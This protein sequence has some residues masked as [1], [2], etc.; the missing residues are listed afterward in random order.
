MGSVAQLGE[1]LRC[2][3]EGCGFDSL[4][5][6]PS[7]RTRGLG[8]T[9]SLTEMSTR[10]LHWRKWN[11]GGGV[12][13][14]QPCH[15]HVPTVQKFWQPQ[16][17]ECLWACTGVARW[18]RLL[19]PRPRPPY[20]QV[21]SNNC[22]VPAYNKPWSVDSPVHSQKKPPHSSSLHYEVCKQD[23]HKINNL[24]SK[25]NLTVKNMKGSLD[26]RNVTRHMKYMTLVT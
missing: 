7:C 22:Q 12:Q 23:V 2:K 18:G 17:S 3:S 25:R 14:W 9:Q 6:N 16:L 15:F 19:T 13:G 4:S 1:A 5:L 10:D 11:K 26:L 24:T 8:S 20:Q 21:C